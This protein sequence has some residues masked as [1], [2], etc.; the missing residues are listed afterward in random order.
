MQSGHGTHATWALSVALPFSPAEHDGRLPVQFGMPA[1]GQL[2][3]A[4]TPLQLVQVPPLVAQPLVKVQA[5]KP[6]K[7]AIVH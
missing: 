7:L 4:S 2:D 5:E 6:A 1:G 3:G